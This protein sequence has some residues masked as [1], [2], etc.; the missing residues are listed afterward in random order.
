M[1]NNSRMTITWS[2]SR[3]NKSKNCRKGGKI[4]PLNSVWV[5]NLYVHGDSQGVIRIPVISRLLSLTILIINLCRTTYQR[6]NS[7]MYGC[8][9][10]AFLISGT[11]FTKCLS[12]C[13]QYFVR[14]ICQLLPMLPFYI[15]SGF[16][17]GSYHKFP[18]KSTR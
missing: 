9:K 5:P 17:S 2:D 8:Q 11:E 15:L 3:F 7:S 18:E 4:A 12:G 14:H 13:Y 1:Y 6:R 10:K 16:F